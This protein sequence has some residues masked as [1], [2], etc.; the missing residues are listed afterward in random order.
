MLSYCGEVSD[1]SPVGFISPNVLPYACTFSYS[2]QLLTVLS[3][4]DFT[5]PTDLLLL[6]IATVLILDVS[7]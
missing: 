1:F 3:L 5:L 7:A 2:G 4:V 6:L